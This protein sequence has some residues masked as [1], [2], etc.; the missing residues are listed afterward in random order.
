MKISTG[1]D[2]F[3][4]EIPSTPALV[5]GFKGMNLD[6]IQILRPASN[7]QSRLSQRFYGLIRFKW[8]LMRFNWDLM[9]IDEV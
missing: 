7:S 9:G 1:E 2:Q 6:S 3:H 5:G 8:D 4:Q